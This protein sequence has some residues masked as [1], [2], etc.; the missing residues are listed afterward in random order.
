MGNICLLETAEVP[1]SERK[2]EQQ[3]PVANMGCTVKHPVGSGNR[4]FSEQHPGVPAQ[5]WSPRVKCD[6][7]PTL[8][9]IRQLPKAK[10]LLQIKPRT[11]CPQKIEVPIKPSLKSNLQR[12]DLNL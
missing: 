3:I 5:T 8:V 9:A 6:L 11:T 4:G 12:K 2:E 10:L 7:L 1:K